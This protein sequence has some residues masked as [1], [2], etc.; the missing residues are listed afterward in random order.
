MFSVPSSFKLFFFFW[1]VYV[2]INIILHKSISKTVYCPGKSKKKKFSESVIWSHLVVI[3]IHNYFIPII[4]TPTEWW[5]YN[6]IFYPRE[7][8][9]DFR[10][11]FSLGWT[12]IKKKKKWKAIYLHAN[13]LGIV[14]SPF[15]IPELFSYGLIRSL[16]SII[17]IF[18]L[19]FI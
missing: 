8:L 7:F 2:I 11:S 18:Y 19:F 13:L 17:F 4:T 15:E 9:I 6:R 1:R 14:Y 10:K 16:Q 5:N 12:R 3:I